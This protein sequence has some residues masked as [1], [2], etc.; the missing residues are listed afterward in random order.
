MPS[1]NHTTEPLSGRRRPTPPT[2]LTAVLVTAALL[3]FWPTGCTQ[4]TP[5]RTIVVQGS[6]VA[7][8]ADA[9]TAPDTAASVQPDE[10][11]PAAAMPA[12]ND[13]LA[14]VPAAGPPATEDATVE[15]DERLQFSLP[16]DSM[17]LGTRV[18][19]PADGT[20]AEAASVETLVV[21]PGMFDPPPDAEAQPVDSARR[22]LEGRRP[23]TGSDAEDHDPNAA[24]GVMADATQESASASDGAAIALSML[25]AFAPDRATEE[26][27]SPALIPL[28]TPPDLALSIDEPALPPSPPPPAQPVALQGPLGE[29][30]PR[31]ETSP[32]PQPVRHDDNVIRQG[33]W[34]VVCYQDNAV[35]FEH[36]RIYRVWR[37]DEQPPQWAY[38]TID[39]I[40]FRGRMGTDLN[41]T[42]LRS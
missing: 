24:A 26:P 9:S 25:A 40:R 38:E 27:P 4:S 8:A 35:V 1:S 42:F 16:N 6:A 33:P 20:E 2:G 10:L 7:P 34:S 23:G 31:P 22:V 36:D 21:P 39:G 37:A 30:G 18:S 11:A 14:D 3:G 13:T 29:V 19:T 32:A 28:E 5:T 17:V 12:G 41:C 15:D